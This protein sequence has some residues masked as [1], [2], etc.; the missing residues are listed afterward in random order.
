MQRSSLGSH[1]STFMNIMISNDTF[2]ASIFGV[3]HKCVI[4]IYHV[5]VVVAAIFVFG[6][7]SWEVG[8]VK[9]VSAPPC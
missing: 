2:P 1:E 6:M 7:K 4:A 9:I 3:L 8:E 5:H